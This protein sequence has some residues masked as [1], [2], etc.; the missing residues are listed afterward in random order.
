M[1]SE[2]L[3]VVEA[4]Q[5]HGFVIHNIKG[6]SMMPLLNQKTDSVRLEP[7]A[8]RL[9]LYDIALYRRGDGA[10]VLHRVI[11]VRPGSY[12]I[13]GDNCVRPEYVRDD[14]ILAVAV[15]I[16][17]GKEYHACDEPAIRRYA[18]RQKMTL[19]LRACGYYVRRVGSRVKRIFKGGRT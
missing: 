13:R 6:V 1:A 15:G 2:I 7:C 8:G 16:F 3:S 18:V 11:K 17:K 9:K 14:Q 12:V 19:P 10:L 5:R 4:L